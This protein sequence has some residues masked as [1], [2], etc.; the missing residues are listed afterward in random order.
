VARYKINSNKLVAF[1]YTKDGWTEKEIGEAAPFTILSNNIKISW[2]N[3]MTRT[4]SLQRRKLKTSEDGK[5]S[6]AHGLIGLT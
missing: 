6:Y 4:S 2:Y 1:L 5:F 3:A